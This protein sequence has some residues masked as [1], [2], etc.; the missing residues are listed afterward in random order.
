M[1][2]P[3]NYVANG[4]YILVQVETLH[5]D[6]Q[7]LHTC[8]GVVVGLDPDFNSHLVIGA[9]IYF[10]PRD[11]KILDSQERILAIHDEDI[12]ARDQAVS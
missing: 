4:D 11:A 5:V 8:N 3:K 7:D 9:H 2:M 1:M 6:L 12:V 10:D